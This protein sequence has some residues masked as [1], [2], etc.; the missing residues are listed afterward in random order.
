MF[1]QVGNQTVKNLQGQVWELAIA[2]IMIQIHLEAGPRRVAEA[3]AGTREQGREFA[4]AYMW[5]IHIETGPR[6]VAEAIAG[7]A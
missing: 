1:V 5:R 6:R 3:N 2:C 4:L 7:K